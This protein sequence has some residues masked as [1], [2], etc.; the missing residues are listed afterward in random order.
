MDAGEVRP[1]SSFKPLKI[2]Q[3]RLA[4]LEERTIRL[5]PGF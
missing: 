1:L 3:E 2:S 5:F 4:D